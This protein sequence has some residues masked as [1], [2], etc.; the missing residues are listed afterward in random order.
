MFC[1]YISLYVPFKSILMSFET[2]TMPD[3]SNINVHRKESFFF[4]IQQKI[5][6]LVKTKRWCDDDSMFNEWIDFMGF[7]WSLQYLPFSNFFL[8]S[9]RPFHAMLQHQI[10]IERKE[11]FRPSTDG[12]SFI[13]LLT[14]R[15]FEHFLFYV[16]LNLCQYH[17]PT[18]T[19]LP[20]FIILSF[21]FR[22]N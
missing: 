10:Y 18:T 12:F 11:I 13:T 7:I 22:N 5:I 21:V 1:Q 15:I 2:Q 14:G 17:L 4:G 20:S 8:S 16:S 3:G 19:M 6:W 9:K